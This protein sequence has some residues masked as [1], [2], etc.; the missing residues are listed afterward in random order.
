MKS[1]DEEPLTGGPGFS[2]LTALLLP[3]IDLSIPDSLKLR[4]L[5]LVSETI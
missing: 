1:L 4:I 2:N 5:L 3:S